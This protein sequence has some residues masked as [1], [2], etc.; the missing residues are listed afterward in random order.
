MADGAKMKIRLVEHGETEIEVDAA[1]FAD[2]LAADE[3]D[4][5]LDTDASDMSTTT[6]AVLPDGTALSPF[7]IHVKP[8]PSFRT[9]SSMTEAIEAVTRAALRGVDLKSADAPEDIA[10]TVARAIVD[11]ATQE[12]LVILP[13]GD[14]DAIIDQSLAAAADEIERDGGT[15]LTAVW[16]ADYLRERAGLPPRSA[17]SLTVPDTSDTSTS[18]GT[19]PS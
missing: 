9:G 14:V 12:N 10:R 16:A 6:L 4:L 1:E 7:D 15:V 5:F 19:S 18:K 3:L 17:K 2:A 11:A 13:R 8:R